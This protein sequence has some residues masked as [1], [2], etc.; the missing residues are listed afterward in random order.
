M[1]GDSAFFRHLGEPVFIRT[2]AFYFVGVV[3]SVFEDFVIL[4]RCSYVGETGPFGTAMA[5]GRFETVKLY[6]K[7]MLVNVAR[8]AI[9][10]FC[11]FVGDLDD[12]GPKD[13]AKP[14]LNVVPL[15]DQE[16]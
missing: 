15:V 11:P 9:I 10:D 14:K 5:S 8:A 3:D 12:L 13:E 6:P 2:V 16:D 1:S 7:D 4:S